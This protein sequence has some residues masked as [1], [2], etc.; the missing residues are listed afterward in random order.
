MTWRISKHVDKRRK[1]PDL[2]CKVCPSIELALRALW[3]LYNRGEDRD[4]YG[5]LQEIHYSTDTFCLMYWHQHGHVKVYLY[6]EPN[7]I[8]SLALQ[9]DLTDAR[10]WNVKAIDEVLESMRKVMVLDALADV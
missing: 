9:F 8:K 2:D 10:K 4:R 3:L 5:D 1:W 6:S 7:R